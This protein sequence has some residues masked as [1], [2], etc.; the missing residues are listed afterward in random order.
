VTFASNQVRLR[1]PANPLKSWTLTKAVV[2][3]LSASA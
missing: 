3:Q 2:A 1:L